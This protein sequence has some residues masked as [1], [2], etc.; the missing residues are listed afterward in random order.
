M[1]FNTLSKKCILVFYL[2]QKNAYI[3]ILDRQ[4]KAFIKQFFVLKK[5]KWVRVLNLRY[6]RKIQ[7]AELCSVS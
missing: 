5:T 6:I 4:K 3:Y 1:F 7:Y 2:S